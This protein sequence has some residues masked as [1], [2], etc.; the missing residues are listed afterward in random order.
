MSNKAL[1]MLE[2]RRD[3]ILSIIQPLEFELEDIDKAI[4]QIKGEK[5]YD[6]VYD[7]ESA[8]HI[9]GTEDGI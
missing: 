4:A 6:K 5:F 7:D 2:K 3:E 9:R 1:Q 8:D